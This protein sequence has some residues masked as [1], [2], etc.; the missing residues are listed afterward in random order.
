[1]TAS[2][3]CESRQQTIDKDDF[4]RRSSDRDHE[5]DRSHANME[6]LASFTTLLGLLRG[7][8]TADP[9]IERLT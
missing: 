5:F 7:H 3:S 4:I 1:M 9:P 2:G 6:R 8:A